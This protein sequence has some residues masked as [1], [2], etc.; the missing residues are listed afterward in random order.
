MIT[1][2]EI[3]EEVARRARYLCMGDR[4]GQGGFKLGTSR[5]RLSPMKSPN[6]SMIDK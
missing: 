1:D 3:G 5:K 6:G 2:E 4:K